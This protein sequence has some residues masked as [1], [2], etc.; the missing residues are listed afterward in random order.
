MTDTPPTEK[1]P[2]SILKFL[3]AGTV[4]LGML[5]VATTGW[6]GWQYW[7][8]PGPLAKETTV[9]IPRGA[10]GK[11]IATQ[12]A[13]AGVIEYPLAFYAATRLLNQH[14]NLKA[15]E[16]AFMPSLTPRDV[17]AKIASGDVVL[18]RLTLPEGLTSR[19]ILQLLQ[20]ADGLEGPL[21]DSVPEGAL[22]PETYYYSLG[23][24]RQEVL[25]RMH[26]AMKQAMA[27]LW[28]SRADGL[29]IKT[30]KDALILASIVEKE[31]GV[32]EER[33][34]VAAVFINRLRKGMPLQ[35]DPTVI[36]ALTRGKEELGRPLT[37]KDL[38]VN[39]PYNTYVTGGLPP[40]PIANPGRASLEAVL[41][42]AAV[43]ALY[44]VADGTGGH[45][46]ARTLKEHNRNV[47][48]WKK[49]RANSKKTTAD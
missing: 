40:T 41:H 28:E 6:W 44:F 3:L 27:E 49:H 48:A 12:L 42:P 5:V 14:P 25:R 47:S 24:T 10:G 17:L 15:G 46:F 1:A 26:E 13:N 16:Y 7:Q 38:K 35:S 20:D 19:E 36:Y 2:F 43:D 33:P 22:L 39:S 21:P 37:R 30:Q 31:T 9:V 34:Q 32:A 8:T 45:R 4:I 29:P 18:R 11:Q 23:D